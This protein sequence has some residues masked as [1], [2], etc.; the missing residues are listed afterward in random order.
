MLQMIFEQKFRIIN[1]IDGSD[2]NERHLKK[3]QKVKNY[4]KNRKI[5]VLS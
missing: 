4:K 5:I 2:E 3:I 1:T